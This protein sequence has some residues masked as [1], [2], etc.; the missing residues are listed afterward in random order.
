MRLF[1]LR[2]Q[3]YGMKDNPLYHFEGC[4]TLGGLC[5]PLD[6]HRLFGCT[7]RQVFMLDT[8]MP[9]DLI[10]L[11]PVSDVSFVSNGEPVPSGCS[12]I[13]V[14]GSSLYYFAWFNGQALSDSCDSLRVA[15]FDESGQRARFP[16]TVPELQP[17]T[18]PDWKLKGR[19][20]RV[21]IASAY[22]YNTSNLDTQMRWDLPLT[23]VSFTLGDEDNLYLYAVNAI[24]DLY[25]TSFSKS[26][27]KAFLS[28]ESSRDVQFG[29]H[30]KPFSSV[31]VNEQLEEFY[32]ADIIHQK[33]AGL[34]YK[35][36]NTTYQRHESPNL[37]ELCKESQQSEKSTQSF[38]DQCL[39]SL[40]R[41]RIDTES[42]DEL[43]TKI[44]QIMEGK[45]TFET[46]HL[47]TEENNCSRVKEAKG[48]TFNKV[49]RRSD[50]QGDD[51]IFFDE[52][53]V[54]FGTLDF[55]YTDRV[56]LN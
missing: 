30:T 48:V 36:A 28:D 24:G 35:L 3:K 38:D 14:A 21:P 6:N 50:Q 26:D 11:C 16:T 40:E 23:G 20:C 41:D 17:F 15:C 31:Q 22:A 32:G 9:R 33:S 54:K 7:N 53:W 51:N 34:R 2:S 42:V 45:F 19:P 8:R 4:E 25:Q 1:D 44:V 13:K 29:C 56:T 5:Q 52:T 39:P 27:H 55:A 43:S 12:M 46:E 10:E 37:A 47:K 49:K 18:G